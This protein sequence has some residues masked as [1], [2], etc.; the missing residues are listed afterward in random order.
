MTGRVLVTGGAGFIGSHVADAYLESGYEVTVLDNLSSGRQENVPR[1]TK[2][3]RADIGS[4]EARRLVATG[5]FT[6][7]NH[8]AA[9]IDVRI[10]VSDPQLDARINILGL[11]NL[12]EGA[13]EGGVRRGGFGG[14]GGGG[15]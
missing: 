13:R 8:H 4:P 11:V 2:L 5:G 12:L 6:L 3:V 7:L 10:S 15:G 14:W 1:G 9:Q